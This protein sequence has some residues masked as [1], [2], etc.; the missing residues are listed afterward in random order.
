MTNAEYQRK[1]IKQGPC[2]I[3]TLHRAIRRHCREQGIEPE[4]ALRDAMTDMRHL[5]DIYRLNF[6]EVDSDA[7]DGYR[8]ELAGV[9]S[10]ELL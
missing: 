2:L 10:G 1:R 3:A 6:A 9:L 4:S 8:E 5:A 7:Y